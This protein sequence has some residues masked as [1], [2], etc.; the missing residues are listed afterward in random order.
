M[1]KNIFFSLQNRSFDEIMWK[2][3][4]SQTG[5]RWEYDTVRALCMLDT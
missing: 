1:F 4:D 3:G 5:H 2:N